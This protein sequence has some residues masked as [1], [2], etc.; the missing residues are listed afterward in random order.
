MKLDI[1]R[2]NVILPDQI[3]KNSRVTVEDGVISG[4][5]CQSLAP[6]GET[7]DARGAYLMPGMIDIH[8]DHIEQVAEP[9]PGCLMDI[10][11][12][13]REQEKQLINQGITTMFHSLTLFRLISPQGGDVRYGKATRDADCFRRLADGV[14]AAG[15]RRGLIRHRLHVRFEIG[16]TDGLPVLTEL[17]DS[18]GVSLVSFMDHT[19]G[20]GQYRDVERFRQYAERNLSAEQFAERVE[21]RRAAPKLS[22]EALV[23]AAR[24]ARGRGIPVS[25]H[26]DDCA[27]KIDFVRDG[28]GASVSEFPVETDV[29]RYA[30]S[31]G[32]ATLGGAPNIMLGYSHSGNMSATD[33]VL[34]GCISCICSDYYPPS[35][36][37]AVFKLHTEFGLP[38]HETARLATLAP[39][40]AVGIGARIGSVAAG[41]AA[42]L[43]VVD[44]SGPMARVTAAITNGVVSSTLNYV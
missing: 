20:Q 13:L 2:A 35:M 1:I 26:D 28:L 12:A 16:G 43:L 3:I 29:A 27:E 30:R 21:Q 7:I 9:R 31:K 19:P 23:Q 6:R 40:E 37:Q 15:R 41:K 34:D 38:L 42:D 4:V 32:M 25:S 22:R 8:S 36:L 33:G 18:G 39:A 24:D 10:D 17:M 14:I 11:F 5:D 44:A